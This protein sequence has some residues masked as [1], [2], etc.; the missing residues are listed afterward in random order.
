[1]SIFVK[2]GPLRPPG[3]IAARSGG[4]EIRSLVVGPLAVVWLHR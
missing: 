1:M 3:F 4:I 2:W